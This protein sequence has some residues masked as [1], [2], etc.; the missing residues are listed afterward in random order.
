MNKLTTPVAVIIAGL[1][2]GGAVLYTSTLKSPSA[3]L[4]TGAVAPEVKAKTIE[5][6]AQTAGLDLAKFTSCVNDGTYDA[7][8]QADSDEAL[9][10]GA[11]GTPFT[12]VIAQ[13]GEKFTIPGAYPYNDVKATV[14]KALAAKGNTE[15]AVEVDIPAVSEQDHILG[16]LDAPVKLV[17]YSDLQCPFCGR[18]HPTMQRVAKEYGDQ[19]AW[20]YRHFPLESIHPNARP[21]A[22]AAE[23]AANLGGND[24]FWK[25]IDAVFGEMN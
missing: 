14:A 23:C 13:N 15:G 22:N 9:V 19:V 3:G 24:G 8:V 7:A 18:F 1:I 25:F 2:I 16:S 11:Q 20:V 6:F 10:A 17:E 4:D 12:V 21:L 5:D